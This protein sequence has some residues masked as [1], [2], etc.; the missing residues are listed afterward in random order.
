MKIF[1]RIS[2]EGLLDVSVGE[3][4]DTGIAASIFDQFPTNF[5]LTFFEPISSFFRPILD[6][7]ETYI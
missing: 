7:F 6:D 4:T 3:Q 1:K 2:G 5:F